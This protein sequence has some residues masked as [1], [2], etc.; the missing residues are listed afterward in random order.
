MKKTYVVV[1]FETTGLDHN[2]AQITEIGAVKLNENFEEVGVFHT[3]VNLKEG[4]EL[5]K[6]TKITQEMVDSGMLEEQAVSLLNSFIDES[7]VVAQWAPF[8]LSFLSNFGIHPKKF[9][10]T[11]S[12][13]S[14]VEPNESSSLGPTCERLGINLIN[15]HRALDDARA[16]GKVLEVRMKQE[17]LKVMNTIVVTEGRPLSFIPRN[18]RHI[19][20]KAGDLIV[21]FSTKKEDA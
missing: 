12:L 3:F 16:T 18:T 13:T 9:I 1:D 5:S 15:A 2:T 11:K 4:N 8:D 14:Q 21:D 20:T 19:L 7:I 10:C 6:F 17:G